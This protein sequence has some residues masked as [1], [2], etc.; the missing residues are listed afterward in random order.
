MACG[1]LLPGPVVSLPSGWW[2][3]PAQSATVRSTNGSDGKQIVW[4]R[5]GAGKQN[6]TEFNPRNTCH[7]DSGRALVYV[8]RYWRWILYLFVFFLFAV[9]YVRYSVLVG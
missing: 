6:K 8:A 4:A 1:S 3:L 5:E 9:T 2:T 7:I